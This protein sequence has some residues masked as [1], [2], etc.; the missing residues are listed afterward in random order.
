MGH[1]HASMVPAAATNAISCNLANNGRRNS[2]QLSNLLCNVLKKP[3]LK[4]LSISNEILS[5]F[6]ICGTPEY[7]WVTTSKGLRKMG[8]EWPD[9][10]DKIGFGSVT[11]GGG[12]VFCV[13][14]PSLLNNSVGSGEV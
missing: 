12:D 5:K 3:F 8:S 4:S 14:I 10:P 2:N 7:Q 1:L 6:G 11:R 13:V 9:K